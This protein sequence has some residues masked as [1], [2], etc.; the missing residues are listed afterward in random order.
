MRIIKDWLKQWFEK[1]RQ[2]VNCNYRDD[3]YADQKCKSE[4]L[5]T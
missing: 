5:K 3:Y 4:D 1:P 2:R